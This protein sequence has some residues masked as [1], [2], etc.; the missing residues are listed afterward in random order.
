MSTTS[1]TTY[2][3]ETRNNNYYNNPVPNTERDS[4]DAHVTERTQALE[5]RHTSQ[6]QAAFLAQQKDSEWVA[7]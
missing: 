2:D 3:D 4:Y 1:D 7:R 5:E 6:Q